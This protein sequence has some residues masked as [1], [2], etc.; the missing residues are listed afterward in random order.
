MDALLSCRIGG[1]RCERSALYNQTLAHLPPL[2]L[3]TLHLPRN[4]RLL[5][6]GRVNSGYD[7]RAKT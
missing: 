7:P 5:M 6:F 1:Y 4:T 3:A 2:D